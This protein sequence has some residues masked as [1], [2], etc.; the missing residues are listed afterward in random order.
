MART[1]IIAEV[2]AN[3]AGEFAF[4]TKKMTEKSFEEKAACVTVLSKIR[5]EW[6]A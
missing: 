6:E 2:S 4:V 5:T 3:V 1:F